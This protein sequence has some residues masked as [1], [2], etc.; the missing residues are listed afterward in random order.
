M[1]ARLRVVITPRA[2][3]DITQAHA[4]YRERSPRAAET[5]VTG[6]R[7][8]IEHLGDMPAAHPVTPESDAIGGEIRRAL[9]RH[10]TPWRIY[11]VVEDSAVYVLHVRHGSRRAWEP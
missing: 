11:Y 10:G 7:E 9:Y 6:I 1:T 3:A 5:W 2:A 4:W 8:I